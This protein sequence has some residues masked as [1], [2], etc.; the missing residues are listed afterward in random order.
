MDFLA[1]FV[2]YLCML[3]MFIT[4]DARSKRVSSGNENIVNESELEKLKDELRAR[5]EVNRGITD[6]KKL[7][8][9]EANLVRELREW[10]EKYGKYSKERMVK[11]NALGQVLYKQKRFDD[12]LEVSRE[13]V[14]VNEIVS[15][16]ETPNTAYA[17]GNYGSVS[18][19]VGNLRECETAMNRALNILINL[20]GQ[21][22]KEVVTHRAKMEMYKVHGSIHNNGISYE[23]YKNEEEL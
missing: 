13:L 2:L 20:Y 5:Q 4:V 18:Y 15:G 17:L 22:S 10:T 14:D 12:V 1:W 7:Q 19:K 8:E 23:D 11:L 9:E 3:N 16:P 21:N 6:V